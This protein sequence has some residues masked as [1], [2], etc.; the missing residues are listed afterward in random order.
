MAIP[1]APQPCLASRMRRRRRSRSRERRRTSS[2]SRSRGRHERDRGR[3]RSRSRERR[4]RHSRSRERERQRY[5]SRSHERRHGGSEPSRRP[6][7]SPTRWQHGENGVEFRCLSTH[8]MPQRAC[9]LSGAVASFHLPAA[10]STFCSLHS[11]PHPQTATEAHSPVAGA[12]SR[13]CRQ[14]WLCSRR[15]DWA[16][17]HTPC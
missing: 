2:R 14:A 9:L 6:G 15:L 4:Q 13:M 7:Q 12:L 10:G 16:S 11:P 8:R 17:T 3:G 1:Y 5:R